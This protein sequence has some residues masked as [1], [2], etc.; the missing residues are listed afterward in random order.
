MAD[1][2]LVYTHYDD[3]WALES[4]QIPSL[5][6]GR[7]TLQELVD[8][9]D[10]ILQLAEVSRDDFDEVYPHSQHVVLSPDGA[11]YLVRIYLDDNEVRELS[12]GRVAMSIEQGNEVKN[13]DLQP[14]LATGERLIIA[15]TG[16]DRIGWFMAQL[17]DEEGAI[18]EW[19]KVEDFCYSLPLIDQK[20]GTDDTYSLES[21]GLDEDSTVSEWLDRVIAAEASGMVR[22][23]IATPLVTH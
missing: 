2:H 1:L 23:H 8:D 14:K 17:R 12:A 21:L 7:P 10:M 11:E 22:E 3:F 18:I 20:F 15:A 6:G 19:N 9:T 5:V 13:E 16:T 4:P